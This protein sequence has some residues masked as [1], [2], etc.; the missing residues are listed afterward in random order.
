MRKYK[1]VLQKY[2]RRQK[3]KIQFKGKIPEEIELVRDGKVIEKWERSEGSWKS[4]TNKVLKDGN[5]GRF[6]VFEK[7]VGEKKNKGD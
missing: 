6:L 5:W 1:K 2:E 4:F 3:M 7:V